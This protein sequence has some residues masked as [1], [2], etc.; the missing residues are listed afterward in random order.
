MKDTYIVG[1]DMVLKQTKQKIMSSMYN[2]T[3]EYR[4]FQFRKDQSN[5]Y[6]FVMWITP[7]KG[8]RKGGIVVADGADSI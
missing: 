4:Q 7:S 5:V 3:Y 1:I 2:R 8:G 6:L